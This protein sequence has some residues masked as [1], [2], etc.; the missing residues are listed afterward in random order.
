MVELVDTGDLKSPERK[1]VPVQVRPEAPFTTLLY[2][3][4]FGLNHLNDA[5]SVSFSV[6]FSVSL[7]L[8]V[9][10]CYAMNDN[11]FMAHKE[12]FLQ[13]NL[14]C[15]VSFCVLFIRTSMLMGV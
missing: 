3:T 7:N 9:R 15:V 12:L 5:I 11:S 13:S 10:I 14:P 8:V 2:F 6:S 1:F 4:L